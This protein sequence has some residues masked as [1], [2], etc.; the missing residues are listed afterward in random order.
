M[1]LVT[2]KKRRNRKDNEYAGVFEKA[3]E[4]GREMMKENKTNIC[5]ILTKLEFF[6]QIDINDL[7]DAILTE[8]TDKQAANILASP[9]P[10]KQSSNTLS[11]RSS[12]NST[13]APSVAKISKN[14]NK[15]R[16]PPVKVFVPYSSINTH[17]ANP[18]VASYAFLDMSTINQ[19]SFI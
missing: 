4:Q 19:A 18:K 9:M 14:G 11:I 3:V 7:A 13:N 16:E 8:V 1:S 5:E 6:W 12:D 15:L 2:S 17:C 10:E